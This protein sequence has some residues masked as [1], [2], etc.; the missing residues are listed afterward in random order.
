MSAQMVTSGHVILL[1]FLLMSSPSFA[2]ATSVDRDNSSDCFLRGF[3]QSTLNRCGYCVGGDT[4]LASDY[5]LDCAGTCGLAF[6]DCA[7]KCN[8]PSYQDECTLECVDGGHDSTVGPSDSNSK[9][10][11]SKHPTRDC[12][13]LC[14]L[15]D[16]N[17]GLEYVTDECGICI[18]RPPTVQ[19]LSDSPLKNIWKAIFHTTT[20]TEKPEVTSNVTMSNALHTD[21]PVYNSNVKSVFKDCTGTCYTPATAGQMA[22]VSETTCD[23]CVAMNS[24]KLA[25]MRNACGRCTP[26]P[27]PCPCPI[28]EQDAC[29]VCGGHNDTCTTIL[30]AYPTIVPS[31]TATTVRAVGVTL[32]SKYHSIC[33]L[34]RRD[35]QNDGQDEWKFPAEV[36][37]TDV[38]CTVTAPEGI[39]SL[40]LGV[41]LENGDVLTYSNTSLPFLVYS[42]SATIRTMSPTTSTIPRSRPDDCPLLITFEALELQRIERLFCTVTGKG[43]D[44]PAVVTSTNVT[45]TTASCEIPYPAHSSVA[46]INVTLDLGP[47]GS[48]AGPFHLTFY[49]SAPNVTHFVPLPEGDRLVIFFDRNVVTSNF[50]SVNCSSIFDPQSMTS[51]GDNATCVWVTKRQLMVVLSPSKSALNGTDFD[52]ENVILI[53]K[54]KTIFTDNETYSEAASNLTIAF[55]LADEPPLAILVGPSHTVPP[56][57]DFVLD[58]HQSAGLQARRAHFAWSVSVRPNNFPV[59]T[60]SAFSSNSKNDEHDDDDDL[61]NLLKNATA[62]NQAYV[63]VQSSHLKHDL[64]YEFALTVSNG[65][66]DGNLVST[67]N[68]TIVRSR[69]P[70]PAILIEPSVVRYRSRVSVDSRFTL[71]AHLD[72]PTCLQELYSIHF[73]WSTLEPRVKFDVLQMNSTSYTIEP[74]TLPPN[75]EVTFEVEVWLNNDMNISSRSS[76]SFIVDGPSV[77]AILA[78]GKDK[79]VGVNSGLLLLNASSSYETTT[80]D[81]PL[82]YRWD[83]VTEDSN[84]CY[85]YDPVSSSKGDTLLV[86]RPIDREGVLSVPTN[87][88]RAGDRMTF[89]VRA[90]S[91]KNATVMSEPQ[92]TI[93]HVTNGS[94]PMVTIES[95]LPVKQLTRT[96]RTGHD[97]RM[98]HQVPFDV[99]VE[100]VA[101]VQSVSPIASVHWEIPGL[102]WDLNPYSINEELSVRSSNWTTGSIVVIHKDFLV[103]NGQYELNV[104]ATDERGESGW[105]TVDFVVSSPIT[106]CRVVVPEYEAFTMIYMYVDGCTASHQSYPLRY[107]AFVYYKDSPMSISHS[108]FH[109]PMAIMGP[110]AMPPSASAAIVRPPLPVD[111]DKNI[112]ES[113]NI[114]A[115]QVCDVLGSCW[116]FNSSRTRVRPLRD[117]QAAAE[118]AFAMA[119]IAKLT[120]NYLTCVRRHAFYLMEASSNPTYLA[121]NDLEFESQMAQ[122]FVCAR[123]AAEEQCTETDCFTNLFTFL[124]AMP[125]NSRTSREYMMTEVLDRALRRIDAHNVTLTATGVQEAFLV[126]EAVYRFNESDV[127]VAKSVSEMEHHFQKI[128]ARS[129]ADGESPTLMDLLGHPVV[130]M[131]YNGLDSSLKVLTNVTTNSTVTVQFGSDFRSKYDAWICQDQDSSICRGVVAELQFYPDHVYRP[132]KVNEAPNRTVSD[133]VKVNLLN[134]HTGNPVKDVRG[135]VTLTMSVDRKR[136]SDDLEYECHYFD[137]DEEKW[138]RNGV[139]TLDGGGRTLECESDHLATFVVIGSEPRMSPWVIAIIAV[140]A[141]LVVLVVAGGLFFAYRKSRSKTMRVS[142]S[143]G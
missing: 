111:V 81:L 40:H 2:N 57:G 86:K 22:V 66:T 60:E 27:E 131:H 18:V 54:E 96:S 88:L 134:P 30:N 62:W 16:S 135:T 94:V 128:L 140:A 68:L 49:A 103:A 59:R 75:E 3:P 91:P 132:V 46:Q 92:T 25:T 79:S 67:D 44:K 117:L 90:F 8:G 45:D 29:G 85:N 36:S 112:N 104:T 114:F 11:S 4:T 64:Q 74:Y 41:T 56:C 138:S 110:P 52:P 80:P 70:V 32:K 82:V 73:R 10:T 58:G 69:V 97:D 107:E 121:H 93:V 78:G 105:S 28:V 113:T 17:D 109:V 23:Q 98:L 34:I 19:T 38:T 83:C 14:Q 5:G 15:A 24:S 115:L 127:A 26:D 61:L 71:T 99:N 133:V 43:Y 65:P 123:R 77:Q 100:V 95:V 13:R 124:T 125:I 122:A 136:M 21:E 7:G 87:R 37:D 116:M 33:L 120:N 55:R 141:T 137:V 108:E 12:R 143:R 51:L 118:H 139:K 6:T 101:V 9:P 142:I 106:N 76:I 42:K 126:L 20:T 84:P 129:L 119:N 31:D 35:I 63:V 102:A 1:L 48:L 89:T 72:K 47:S 39:Y 50:T 53:F 130:A